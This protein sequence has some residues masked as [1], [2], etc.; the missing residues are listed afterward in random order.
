MVEMAGRPAAA[1][2]EKRIE[3]LVLTPILFVVT[4]GVGWLVWSVLE[5]RGGRTPSYRLLGLR[6]VRVSD[7]RPIRF[8]RSLA[9]SSICGLLVIPT[10]AVCCVIG[11][12]F[13]FGASS[14]DDL[15]THP[16][17]APWDYLTATKVTDEGAGRNPGGDF[18]HDE[19]RPIDLS[20]A[21]RL[22]GSQRNGGAHGPR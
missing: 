14:P 12:C 19:L 18:G 15:L 21:I 17:A 6:V 20:R 10:T 7:E 13:L 22:P 1:T 9:R 3:A 2:L 4:L 16:R 5:W 8:A 11:I